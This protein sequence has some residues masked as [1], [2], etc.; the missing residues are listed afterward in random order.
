MNKTRDRLAGAAIAV[1]LQLGFVSIFVYS[2]PL[3]MPA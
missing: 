2:L 1:M 3:I